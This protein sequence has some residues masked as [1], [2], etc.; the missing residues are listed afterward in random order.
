[1]PLLFPMPLMCTLGRYRCIYICILLF[2]FMYSLLYSFV[3]HG[4]PFR[5]YARDRRQEYGPSLLCTSNGYSYTVLFLAFH[6]LD[7]PYS[8]CSRYRMCVIYMYNHIS[9]TCNEYSTYTVC[10]IMKQPECCNP[11]STQTGSALPDIA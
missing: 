3:S 6:F 4:T 7:I 5:Y 10:T 9:K 8:A 1:M 2:T 11:V